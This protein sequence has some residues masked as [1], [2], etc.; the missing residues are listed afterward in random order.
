VAPQA[1]LLGRNRILV[2]GGYVTTA[3]GARQPIDSVEFLSTDLTD[4]VDAPF[5]LTPAALDRAFVALGSLVA[6]AVGGCKPSAGEVDCIPCAEGCISRDVWWIDP[7]GSPHPLEPLPAALAA[8]APRLVPGAGGRPWLLAGGRLGHFD[9]WLGRFVIADAGRPVPS[10][11]RL[12]GQPLPINPGLFAWLEATPSGVEL[13]GF[14][15]SQRGRYA[16]DVAPLLVG[17]ADGV[18]PH[19]PPSEAGPGRLAYSV[20]RGLELS[21]SAAVV[22]VAD[23]DY[24]AFT[25]EL[26]LASGPAPLI[27][28]VAIDGDDDAAFGGFDC[29]W[30]T[31]DSSG[32]LAAGSTVDAGDGDDPGERAS[33]RAGDRAAE[34]PPVRLRVERSLDRVRLERLEGGVAVEPRPEP[35][36]R[37]LPERV[38]IQLVGTPAGVTRLSRIEIRRS[39]E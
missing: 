16:Q 37:A 8:P 11:T 36:R 7:Q 21:G 34:P 3:D 13:V 39:I 5:P 20:A 38:S 31:L 22:A 2:G 18:V 29:P 4:V 1:V 35:C 10:E 19:Q 23:T 24:A 6:L 17:S 25:L 32:E 30:P 12:L 9:P 33:E 27:Q 15:H 28:L 26:S 14:Y